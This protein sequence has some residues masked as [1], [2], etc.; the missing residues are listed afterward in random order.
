[1]HVNMNETGSSYKTKPPAVTPPV[2]R[3]QDIAE[4]NSEPQR[5]LS[6]NATAKVLTTPIVVVGE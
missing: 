2:T 1:M 6:S 3:A 5:K 4:A